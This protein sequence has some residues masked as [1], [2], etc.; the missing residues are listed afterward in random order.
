[1]QS[2]SS[3][4]DI[5]GKNGKKKPIF[6]PY[7]GSKLDI[8]AQ[9][10]RNCG[11]AIYEN[12][13]GPS[14]SQRDEGVDGNPN[15]RK[16]VYDGYVHKCPNCGE[17]LE[18]FTVVCPAC[19][20]EIRDTRSAVSVRELAQKLEKI[21][22]RRAPIPE[23]KKSVMK[24]IFGRDFRNQE[25]SNEVFLRFEN[26]KMQEKASLIRNFS[27]PNAK[28]DILE[29]MIMATSNINTRQG[30]DDPVTKAW[31]DKLDQIYQKAEIIMGDHP[32]F[33][34]IRSMYENKKKEIK[35]AKVKKP[36]ML[37]LCIAAYFFLMFFLWHPSATLVICTA[38][39][40]VCIIGAIL[41]E[42]K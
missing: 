23:E 6:C 3:E 4:D 18:A 13:A 29:F 35:K 32:D 11:E 42:K 39:L 22:A 36:Y 19:G 38:A 21:S 12:S 34:Q 24:T 9:F 28:E 41:F 7:C 15:E 5:S 37:I 25:E 33:D 1:M 2:F 10:C 31:I 26:Q 27:V 17:I 8:G 30:L 20:Y 16:T 14:R 40:S